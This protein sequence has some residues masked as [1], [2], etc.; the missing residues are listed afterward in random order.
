MNWATFYLICFGVGLLFAV[1]S[2]LGTATHFQVL[3]KWHLPHFGHGAHMGG[4]PVGAARPPGHSPGGSVARGGMSPINFFTLMAFLT[5]FGGTGYLL[6]QYSHAW[7]VVALAGA[8]VAG[9]GGGS[10]VFW[11]LVKV[12]LAHEHVLDPADYNLVGVLGKIS[13]PVR[14]GGTGEM[15]FS[16]AGIRRTAGARSED[17]D[18]IPKG[19]EVVI[20]RYERGIAYVRPW[21][22]WTQESEIRTHRLG[23]AV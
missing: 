19:T 3:G 16:Q 9:L 11:F 10:V 15:I 14:A 5:W 7:V 6:T 13:S 23:D 2:F 4:A 18:A 8:T 22:D 17:G 21:E 20:T 1:L 12:L